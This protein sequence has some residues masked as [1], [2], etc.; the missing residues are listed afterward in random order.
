MNR[1]V[2]DLRDFIGL[3]KEEGE[4][5]PVRAEVDWDLELSHIAKLSEEK[6]G[7]VLF[8]EKVKGY[9]TPVV[10]SILSKATRWAMALG[11]PK[12][13]SVFDMA[14]TWIET[15]QKGG[16][17]PKRVYDGPIME[18]QMT[19]D[20]VNVLSF[21]IPR[22]LPDDVGRFFG[23][24]HCVIT[25]DPDNGY[26]NVG[27]YR[28]EVLDEKSIAC[29]FIKG[30][31]GEIALKKY[32]ARNEM[33]PV[34]AA[35]GGDPRLFFLSGSTLPYGVSE[36]D[37][38][39]ALRGEPLEVIESELTGLPIP[40]HAEIVVEGFINPDPK[41]F[42]D[43]GPF[44]EYT[45]YYSGA[46]SPK[47]WVDVKKIYYREKPIFWAEMVGRPPQ[48]VVMMH[49]IA[50]TAAVWSQLQDMKIPGV[51]SLCFTPSSGRFWVVISVKQLYPGHARQVGLAALG[52]A[53]GHYGVKGVILV[54]DDIRADDWDR[55]M[56]ALSVRYNPAA[57]TQIFTGTRC[58]PLDPSL[59]IGQRDVG[60][61]ILLDATMPQHWANKPKLCDLDKAVVEKVTKRWSELG[62]D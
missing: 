38:A 36:Y 31:D 40:A 58:T 10:T 12:N 22:F 7:P 23:T 61:Q 62:L 60:S 52:T 21:P 32:G 13:S 51:S 24:A 28:M 16:I 57:D 37:I 49:A 41:T 47:P 4:F 11:M 35:I 44:G 42:R 18:N 30:K 1:R 3:C 45:G 6:G 15:T 33:L 20:A 9:A 48:A 2:N 59:P 55:V 39:G 5:K 14:K 27:T 50:K 19:G 26:V 46:R 8:F 43:E 53:A 34:A 25:R 56:W 17:P 29:Y 54:D